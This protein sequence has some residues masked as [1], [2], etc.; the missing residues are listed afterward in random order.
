M[1]I[2]VALFEKIANLIILQVPEDQICASC[3]LKEE[4]LDEIREDG[5][6]RDLLSRKATE[7]IENAKDLDD[8]WET[9]EK[10]ALGIVLKKLQITGDADFALK[11]GVMA[12]KSLKR[13]RSPS[14]K[15]INGQL[16]TRA[17]I[18]L[19][20][21]FTQ[22]VASEKTQINNVVARADI[23]KKQSD[24]MGVKHVQKLLTD[25]ASEGIKKLMSEMGG[26]LAMEPAE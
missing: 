2:N 3:G 18:F 14:N 23:P 20:P 9:T 16:G 7:D 4:E 1:E 6:F 24:F 25:E 11:C 5:Y 15:P 21:R 8:A 19:N 22:N 13:H 17:V 10:L 26:E 12:N